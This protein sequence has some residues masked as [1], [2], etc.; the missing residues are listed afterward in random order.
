MVNRKYSNLKTLLTIQ[1]DVVCNKPQMN[2]KITYQEIKPSRDLENFVHSF[3]TSKNESNV[4][5]EVTISP[6]S[7][8]KIIFFVQGEKIINYFITGIWTEKKDFII[9][10]N[11]TIFGCRLKILAPEYLLNKEIASLLDSLKQLE[12]SYLNINNFTLSD[13]EIIVK[14]WEV[15]LSRLKPNKKIQTNKLRLSQLLY[16]SNGDL[17]TSEVSEQIYW[18]NRQINRYLNKYIG[19]SLK[20]YLNIQKIYASYS[21]IIKGELSPNKNN[22]FDQ[23]HFIRSV[24]QYTGETPK[25]VYLKQ[26]DRFIQLK[27]IKE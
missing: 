13:F 8:F 3:W 6:D 11:T 24:K 10:T 14:Q 1:L 25:S 7:F 5:R 19:I 22:Y 23:A 16:N 26:N 2:K 9:P 18:T 12:L 27:H 20:K 15:E 21:Q 17:H 4:H